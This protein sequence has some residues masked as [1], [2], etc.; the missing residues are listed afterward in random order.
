MSKLKK[1]SGGGGNHSMNE[2]NCTESRSAN[3]HR[4]FV[5]IKHAPVT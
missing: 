4:S 1:K 2:D 3:A 5:L